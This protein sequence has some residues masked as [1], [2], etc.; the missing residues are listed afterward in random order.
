[1]CKDGISYGISLV[2]VFRSHN[3][4]YPNRLL[5]EI[6]HFPSYDPNKVFNQEAE[7]IH[8]LEPIEISDS[9]AQ[10]FKSQHGDKCNV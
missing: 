6:E 5:V 4:H 8:S 2:Y 7:L 3:V 10:K 1:M 9:E